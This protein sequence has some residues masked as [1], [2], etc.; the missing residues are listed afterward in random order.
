MQGK[1]LFIKGFLTA[2][3]A[4][5]L[6]VFVVGAVR[7]D[8]ENYGKN[9]DLAY[10]PIDIACS[11]DGSVVYLCQGTT[12]YRSMNAGDDWHAVFTS[13]KINRLNLKGK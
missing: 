10:H 11:S 4:S 5:V 7:H 6:L 1:R 12:V 2:V 13:K 3:V 8:T 9:I